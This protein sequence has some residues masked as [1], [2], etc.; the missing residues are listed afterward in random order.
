MIENH[1]HFLNYIFHFLLYSF[2]PMPK[3]ETITVL[4]SYNYPYTGK[5]CAKIKTFLIFSVL[6]QTTKRM[7]KNGNAQTK[8]S[9][10]KHNTNIY[11]A[12]KWYYT[13][14]QQTIKWVPLF[15]IVFTHIVVSICTQ[16][17]YCWCF[18]SK[19]CLSPIE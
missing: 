10:N 8:N 13:W 19:M 16:K 17:R 7:W 3:S 1:S 14:P 5:R 15:H 18:Y 9:S 12:D 4:L 2:W 11:N 6:L